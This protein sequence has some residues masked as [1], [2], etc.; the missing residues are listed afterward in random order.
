[1]FAGEYTEF[2]KATETLATDYY[3]R[4]YEFTPEEI[5]YDENDNTYLI[6]EMDGGNESYRFDNPD[7]KV[8]EWRSNL[9]ARWEYIPGSA[10]YLVWSQGRMGDDNV[11]TPNIGQ[12]MRN[13]FSIKPHNVFLV[14]LTY[15]I[16]I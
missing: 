7:F 13:L 14:K 15:R 12:D 2:K 8:F 11:G 1:M 10:V 5:I 4:F 3:D 16:S 9:V 6:A